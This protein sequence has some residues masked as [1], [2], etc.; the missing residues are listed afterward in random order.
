MKQPTSYHKRLKNKANDPNITG[1]KKNLLEMME[2][3]CDNIIEEDGDAEEYLEGV[4]LWE[5]E[6]PTN[7]FFARDMLMSYPLEI[8]EWLADL[9]QTAGGTE[10]FE[11]LCSLYNDPLCIK[12]ETQFYLFHILFKDIIS[13]ELY[14]EEDYG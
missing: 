6:I 10:I 5:R 11:S 3:I 14:N 4:I 13:D 9:G 12:S 7:R 2:G 1:L 8:S